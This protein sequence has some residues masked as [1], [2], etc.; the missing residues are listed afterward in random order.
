M[1]F[2]SGFQ[3]GFQSDAPPAAN[4]VGYPLGRAHRYIDPA[5]VYV[6]GTAAYLNATLPPNDP[7]AGMDFR[8][9]TTD[10]SADAPYLKT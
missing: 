2:Q 7:D 8:Y 10:G 5:N 1:S 4:D 6:G 3:D 9:L